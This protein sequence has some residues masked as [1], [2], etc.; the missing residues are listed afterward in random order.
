ML[1]VPAAVGF[2]EVPEEL[3]QATVQ[4]A[5]ANGTTAHA[6]FLM[7]LTKARREFMGGDGNNRT[8]RINDFATLRPFAGEDLSEAFDVLVVPHQ[9]RINPNWD[10]QTALHILTETIK[11]QKQGGVLSELYRLSMYGSLARY[12]PTRLTA[13]LVFKLVNKSDLAVTNPGKVPWQDELEAYGDIAILDFVNFPHLLPPAKVVLI[14][15]TF[16]NQLR[17]IQLYDPELLPGG[18]EKS[19]VE[20]LLRHLEQLT[21]ELVQCDVEQSQPAQPRSDSASSQRAV[22]A[23]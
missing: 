6:L 14:F 22:R 19:L 11:E 9:L 20:P 3:L 17:L 16:R 7:A 5:R 23:V 2:T 15:T 8:L 4:A 12:L 13:G 1:K 18:V 10:E 21:K